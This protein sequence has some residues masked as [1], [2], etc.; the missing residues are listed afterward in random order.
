[1]NRAEEFCRDGKNFVYI[2]FSG[3]KSHSE[4][5]E[6]IDFTKPLIS[7]HPRNSLYT[8][9]N[10]E[11]VRYNSNIKQV[12]LDYLD[13]KRDFVKYAAIF[14]LDGIKKTLATSLMKTCGRDGI[15]FTFS[16]EK[17]IELLLKL[18]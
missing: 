12:L 13:H 15:I 6:A 11:N 14:G 9:T 4:F 5:K 18:D 3:I 16:K 1:M 17:A 8:V 2:D 10:I 7:K